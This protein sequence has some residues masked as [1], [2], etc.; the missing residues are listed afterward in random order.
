MKKSN[1]ISQ[2]EYL[3]LLKDLRTTFSEMNADLCVLSAANEPKHVEHFM[4][5][6]KTRREIIEKVYT[7]CQDWFCDDR[8]EWN[9]QG[10]S[11]LKML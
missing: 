3:Q 7:M 4:N 11:L 2:V 5:A 9:N 6:E 1:R 10:E 8:L